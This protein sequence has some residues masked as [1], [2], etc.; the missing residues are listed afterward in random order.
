MTSKDREAFLQS[1]LFSKLDL[2]TIKNGMEIVCVKKGETVMAKKQFRRCLVYILKG[3][4]SVFK[5]GLDGRRS[6]INS[7]YEGDVFGM[8]TLFYEEAEYP[9]EITAEKDLRLAVFSKETIEKAFSENPEF[10]KAYVVLLSEKIH[11]INKKLAAFLEGEAS[12]KLLRWLIN[13]SGGEQEFTLPCSVSKIAEMLGIGRAS[14][15]RAFDSLSERG[16]IIKE[17]KNIIILKH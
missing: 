16:I 4:A 17:G 1:P 7:F 10:A 13:A 15:Y 8:A 14:V 9:S 3:S 5:I 6:V 11:F 2:D 12:E